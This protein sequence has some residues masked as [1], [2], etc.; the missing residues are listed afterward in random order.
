MSLEF[1]D[2][3]CKGRDT[4]Q[5]YH[6]IKYLN[7]HHLAH[8]K[9]STH[10]NCFCDDNGIFSPEVKYCHP[11]TGA[12]DKKIKDTDHILDYH[13][14]ENSAIANKSADSSHTHAPVKEKHYTRWIS[15][16]AL[17]IL[18]NSNRLNKGAGFNLGNLENNRAVSTE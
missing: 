9:R 7:T 14:R 17:E 13:R 12:I 4:S 1:N 8:S 6:R 2:F 5:N 18:K 15:S 11:E 10:F 16:E 3:T